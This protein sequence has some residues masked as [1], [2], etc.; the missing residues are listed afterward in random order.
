MRDCGT[1]TDRE[2]VH[3][4]AA[5]PRPS[6]NR[7]YPRRPTQ[8]AGCEGGVT[9]SRKMI[10]LTTDAARAILG[11]TADS[12]QD[13][14]RKAWRTIALRSHPDKNPGDSAAAARFREAMDAFKCL[15]AATGEDE[16]KS[17]EALCAEMDDARKALQRAMD[18]AKRHETPQQPGAKEKIL[19]IGGATWVGEVESGRPHGIGDLILPNGSVHHGAFDAGRASGAGVLHDAT[20]SVFRGQWVENK[21]C[22]AFETMD[23]KGG[24]WHD[25]YDAT[26]GKRTSRKKGMPPAP[27]TAGAVKCKQCGAKFHVALGPIRCLLHSGTWMEAP[28]HNADGSAATV[29]RVAFP[30]GGLWLCCGSKSKDAQRGCT[31]GVHAAEP[32]PPPVPEARRIADAEATRAAVAGPTAADAIPSFI[33]SSFTTRVEYEAWRCSF[34]REP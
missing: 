5:P 3:L 18:L 11:V 19:K 9:Q 10:K 23:P 14:I 30:E 21:R 29:D 4:G 22:G 13:A 1:W 6:L 27:G 17:Y 20:G 15:G 24:T 33:E 34:A 28:T 31:L 8:R 2:R 7:G 16:H 32:L 12:S 25:S 26:E